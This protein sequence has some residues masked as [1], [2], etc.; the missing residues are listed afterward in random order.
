M[1]LHENKNLFKQ[2][3][4]SVSNILK[5]DPSIVVKDYYVTM[6]LKCIA[7]S[8]PDLMFKGGTSLSKGYNIIRRFSEDLDLTLIPSN[9]M[10]EGERRK[11]NHS[12]EDCFNSLGLKLSNDSIRYK[13][14]FVCFKAKFPCKEV[15][16]F[17]TE[18]IKIE[19]VLRRKGR[20]LNAPYSRVSITNYIYSVLKDN[21]MNLLSK[22]DLLPFE[23]NV[24]DIRYTLCEK[25]IAVGN[26]Y[27]RGKSERLSRHLYDISKLLNHVDVTDSLRTIFLHVVDCTR[28]RGFD[29]A[30][31]NGNNLETSIYK[32][33]SE[34]FYK[35]DY[36]DISS[37]FIF[38]SVS[39]EHAKH[40]LMWLISIGLC[41]TES[42]NGL[43]Y[44]EVVYNKDNMI[45]YK[46]LK[47]GN[48][49][50][51]TKQQLKTS[52]I[53]HLLTNYKLSAD[54]RLIK[55]FS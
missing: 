29:D 28:N 20:V 5:V 37:K 40:S 4:L 26:N 19:S 27:L 39:Y 45:Q 42:T 35:S 43:R 32:A 51:C 16:S 22:F 12:I 41:D 1:F 48:L 18:E 23:V 7:E 47:T 44:Y 21:S 54:N 11:F 33:L 17:I 14:D 31:I 24:Y 9:P 3:V 10:S 13:S 50:S 15:V 36:I 52:T 49:Y 34:D 2:I 25:L 6:L 8:N 38:D 46:D 30:I 55:R 53:V